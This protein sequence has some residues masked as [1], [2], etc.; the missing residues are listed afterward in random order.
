MDINKKRIIKN[1]AI[2]LAMIAVIVIVTLYTTNENVQNLIDTYIFKK[3]VYEEKTTSIELI[4]D[5]SNIYAY[6]KYIVTLSNG[7][8]TSYGTSGNK[9]FTEDVSISNPIFDSSEKFLAI[10]E[11]GGNII[12]LI[13]GSNIVWQ[14]DLEGEISQINVNKNGYLSV[15]VKGTSYKTVIITYNDKGKE[16]FK[17]YLSSTNAIKTAIS[18]DNKYLALAEVNVSG[19]IIQSNIKIIS[20]QKAEKDPTNSVVN[21]YKLDSGSLI[22]N[23]KYQDRGKLICMLN[24]SIQIIENESIKKLIDIDNSLKYVDINLK[25]AVLSIGEKQKGLFTS[26]MQVLIK[27]TNILTESLYTLEGTINFVETNGSNI[28]INMGSDVHFINTSGWLQKKYKASK[29]ITDIVL[30]DSIAGIVYHDK[31]DVIAL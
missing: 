6:D 11:N 9:E 12:Y 15:A 8:L 1:S 3:E 27:D 5:N 22:T 31:I 17:T 24:D 26:N 28:A 4:N 25:N 14:N 19:S 18:N 2:I 23:I 16:L 7:K 29:E 30:G 13:S 20:L 10:A 21:T